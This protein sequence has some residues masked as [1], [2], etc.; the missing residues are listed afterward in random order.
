VDVN[1]LSQ[2]IVSLPNRVLLTRVPSLLA[3]HSHNG[4]HTDCARALTP[5]ALV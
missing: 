4:S 1:L 2:Q 5:S 3:G